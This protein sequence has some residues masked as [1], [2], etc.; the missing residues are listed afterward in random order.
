MSSY[1]IF[2]IIITAYNRRKF[3]LDALKSIANQTIRGYEVI[4]VKNFYDKLI[5]SFIE[6]HGFKNIFIDTKHYGAQ[7]AVGVE[8]SKGETLLFLEDDDE[9]E[10]DKIYWVKKMFERSKNITFVHDTR[11]Y[12]DVKGNLIDLSNLRYSH[13]IRFLESITPQKD[14]LIDPSNVD[15]IRYLLKYYGAVST[16]SLM[17]VKTECVQDKLKDLK[18]IHISVETFIPQWQANAVFFIIHRED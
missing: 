18:H 10:P 6:K 16:T 1:N 11:K 3:L 17:S 14:V 13:I 15:I 5:D 2:S 7:L 9:F 8:E 4:V 12:I